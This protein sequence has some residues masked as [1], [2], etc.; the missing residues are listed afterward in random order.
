MN[1]KREKERERCTLFAA[2]GRATTTTLVERS[3]HS[4]NISSCPLHTHGG[5]IHST[6]FLLQGP[7]SRL[8]PAM[9]ALSAL[10]A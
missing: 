4:T 5:R 9:I 6:P 7:D 2:Y 10:P 1:P 8:L 3:T